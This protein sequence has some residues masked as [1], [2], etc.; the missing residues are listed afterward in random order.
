MANGKIKINKIEVSKDWKVSAFK[1]VLGSAYREKTGQ[2]NIFYTYDSLGILFYENTLKKIA[3]EK[4]TEC[5][6]F[7]DET[8]ASPAYPTATY[9]GKI[10][11]Q[12]M[13]IS[14]QTTIE[15]VRKKLADYTETTLDEY[16]KYRFSKDGLYLFLLYNKAGRLAR[17]CFGAAK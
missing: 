5:Q 11:V 9:A 2:A 4:V 1:N 8:E 3:S 12:K 13:E 14:N 6:I 10:W 15:E 17:I 16:D 7:L